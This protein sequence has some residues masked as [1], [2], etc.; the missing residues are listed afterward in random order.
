MSR[1]DRNSLSFQHR[2]LIATAVA[3]NTEPTGEEGF[4]RYIN[5]MSDVALAK[6]L[7]ADIGIPITVANVKSVRVQTAGQTKVHRRAKVGSA[8]V[9][10]LREE[11]AGLRAVVQSLGAKLE[12]LRKVVAHFDAEQHRRRAACTDRLRDAIGKN[13]ADERAVRTQMRGAGYTDDEISMAM[14]LA[15]AVVRQNGA[16]STVELPPR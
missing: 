4:C 5:G 16:G 7:T 2:F 15:G 14:Y 3:A 10:A 6:N 1:E 9:A 8:D 13:R 11:V 12:D